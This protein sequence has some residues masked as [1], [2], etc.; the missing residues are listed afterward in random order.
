VPC[1]T[2]DKPVFVGIKTGKEYPTGCISYLGRDVSADD[3]LTKLDLPSG[4]AKRARPILN[5]Y[6]TQLQ[7]FKIGNVLSLS[8]SGM[9]KKLELKKEA[10]RPPSGERKSTLP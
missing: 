4:E 1:L 8:W 3:I 7:D 6:L 9:L 10:E 2:K 5:Q